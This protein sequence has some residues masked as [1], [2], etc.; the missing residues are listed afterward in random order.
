LSEQAD[1]AGDRQNARFHASPN[2]LAAGARFAGLQRDVEFFD[3]NFLAAL[4]RDSSSVW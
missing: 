3:L 2:G 1:V 4:Y